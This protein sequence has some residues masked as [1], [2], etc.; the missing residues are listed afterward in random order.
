MPNDID[1]PTNSSRA[2]LQLKKSIF[3]ATWGHSSLVATATTDAAPF[4]QIE[5]I[6]KNEV[7]ETV[8]GGVE[9]L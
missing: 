4:T 2:T 6:G 9:L 3:I 5:L 8:E 7:D 1:K